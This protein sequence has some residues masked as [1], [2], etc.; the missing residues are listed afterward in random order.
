MRIAGIDIGSRTVKLAVLE[1]GRLIL[2]RKTMTSY[3]PLATAQE[4]MGDAVFDV[5]TATGYGRHL[6]K[7]H[8]DCP[9]ISEIT[10][11]ARGARFF[12]SDCR[13]I[14]DI[15]GQDTKAI[16]LDQEGNLRKFE[17][18]DKCAAGTGR[19]LEV[20]ATALG[21]TIEEFSKAGLS[22]G[23]AVKIN[24]TCTVFAESEVVSLTAQG[25]ARDEVALGIHKAIVS[26]SIGLLKKVAVPGEIFFAGGVAYNDC[27]RVL[28]EKEMG[29]PVFVP[30]DPQIVGAVGAAL[31]SL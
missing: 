16:S 10:A 2:S 11:F 13:S 15:G 27:V 21:F 6:I 25:A 3:N 4:L 17:M 29:Q 1:D 18:N 8:L 5:I 22:A 26:R 12:S 20:M 30:S 28:L 14:L 23:K 7:G 31:S 24:S 9:V 19:F